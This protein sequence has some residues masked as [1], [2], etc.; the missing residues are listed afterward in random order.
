MKQKIMD[1]ARRETDIFLYLT[2]VRNVRRDIASE[3]CAAWFTKKIGV[4]V[5]NRMKMRGEVV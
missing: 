4:L 5:E 3:K 1:L 2:Q